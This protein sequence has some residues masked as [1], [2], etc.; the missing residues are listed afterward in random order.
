MQVSE[1]P[2]S[3]FRAAITAMLVPRKPSTGRKWQP[4]EGYQTSLV[5]NCP[6]PVWPLKSEEDYPMPSLSLL[7]QWG[8]E[9]KEFTQLVHLLFL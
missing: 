5:S 8:R 4:S 1:H 2:L 7:A 3:G 6:S 9:E